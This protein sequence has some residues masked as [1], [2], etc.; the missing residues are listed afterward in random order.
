MPRGG[1][2]AGAGRKRKL[3][4]ETW[5]DAQISHLPAAIEALEITEAIMRNPSIPVDVRLD[6]AKEVMDRVAGRPTQKHDIEMA[7]PI[8][9]ILDA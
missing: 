6:A 7:E 2:R 3:I 8:R 5:R 4:R 1:A 9:I